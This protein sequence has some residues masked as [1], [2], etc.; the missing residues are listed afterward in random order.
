MKYPA[1]DKLEII[2]A[3][4]ASHLP[5]RQTLAMIGIPSSTYYDWCAWWVE[6]SV[7]ALKLALDASG[8]NN[9]T[10]RSKAKVVQR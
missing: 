9:A 3:L 7:D 10:C 1:P 2:H 6:G 4:K 8:T 5:G